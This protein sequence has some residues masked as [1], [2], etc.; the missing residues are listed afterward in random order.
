M[1]LSLVGLKCN[2][3]D[4]LEGMY[5]ISDLVVIYNIEYINILSLFVAFMR[6]STGRSFILESIGNY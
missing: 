2:G 5:E 3:L 6:E 4:M 1:T